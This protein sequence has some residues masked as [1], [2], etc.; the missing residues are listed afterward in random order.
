VTQTTSAAGCYSRRWQKSPR[1]VNCLDV[2][3]SLS[4]LHMSR[5]LRFA[6]LSQ[7]YCNSVRI[8]SL[9]SAVS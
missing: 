5:A 4:D 1:L 7:N 2:C 8:H 9:Q 3:L 6:H